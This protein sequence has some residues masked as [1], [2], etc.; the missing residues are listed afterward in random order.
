[1]GVKLLYTTITFKMKTTITFVLATLGLAQGAAYSS[2]LDS[3]VDDTDLRPG[4]TVTLPQNN[5]GYSDIDFDTSLNSQIAS[6]DT[7]WFFE[8]SLP[9]NCGPQNTEQGCVTE[10]YMTGPYSFLG[11]V[12]YAVNYYFTQVGSTTM[13]S[14]Y[15]NYNNS[16]THT[17]A[18]VPCNGVQDYSITLNKC[19]FSEELY[20]Y[21]FFTQYLFNFYLSCSYDRRSGLVDFNL[22]QESLTCTGESYIRNRF[23][24]VNFNSWSMETAQVDSGSSQEFCQPPPPT[25]T[26][27]AP[28][29]VTE[30]VTVVPT[31]TTTTTTC[32]SCANGDV[33][34]NIQ[35]T[36]TNSASSES[37]V[38][39]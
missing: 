28:P 7:V 3:V 18:S 14:L 17:I 27:V 16:A 8:S 21:Q 37:N 39:V 13:V 29:P 26:T 1:V 24:L 25:T 36:N 32:K 11:Y 34:I 12:P 4:L 5:C 9:S 31:V 35:N 6:N 33:V 2:Y 15:Y 38:Q 23:N 20:H 22:D 10:M 19:M 30:T